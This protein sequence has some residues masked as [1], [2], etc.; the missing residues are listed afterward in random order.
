MKKAVLKIEDMTCEHCKNAVTKAISGVEGVS[1]VNVDLKKNQAE[2]EYDPETLDFDSIREAVEEAG[3]SV[4]GMGRSHSGDKAAPVKV[5]VSGEASDSKKC[6]IRVGGMTCASC[7]TNI[8]KALRRV[9]GVTSANVNFAAESATVEYDPNAVDKKTLEN[10]IADVGYKV[11]TDSI[12]FKITGMTCANCAMNIEKTLKKLEGISSVTVNFATESAIVYYDPSQITPA[13][14]KKAVEDI[15]YGAEEKIEG[16]AALDREMKQRQEEITRQRNNL[17]FAATLGILIMLGSYRMYWRL[18]EFVPEILSNNYMLLLLTTP[19]VLGPARQFFVGTY[20]GLKHGFTDMNLLMATGIGAA[21]LIGLINT[22]WPEVGLGGKHLIFFETAAMLTAFIVLGRYLEALTRGKTSEAIRKL[23]GLQPKNATIMRGGKEVEVSVNE[24]Q[25]GDIVVVKP[26]ERIPVDG[27]VKEGYSSVDESMLTGESIPVEKKV[28]DE[29]IGATIN[30]TGLLRFEATKV[31]KDTALAQIIKLVEEAQGSK[32]PIQKLAD[33]VAG[34]FIVGVHILALLVFFFWFFVGYDLFFTQTAKFVLSPATLGGVGP[35]AFALLLSISVLVIS[36]PCAVGLATPSAV[37]A[38]TGKAAEYG[39]LIKGGEALELAH[40]IKVIVFDKTGTL[41]KGQPSLT[42][43]IAAKGFE[44]DEVLGYAASAEKGSEHPLG[45]AIVNGA[46]S[47]GIRIEKSDAFQAIPGHGIVAKLADK[48]ILL[49]NRKLMMDNGLEKT[50][51]EETL[52]RLEDAGKTAMLVAIDK[53]IIGIVAVADTLK[54]YSKEAVEKLT[55]MGIEVV[56]MTGDNKRTAASIAKQVGIKRVLAEVLPQDKAN[57]I[58]KLQA[59]GKIVAMVG[60]G[61]NDA[62]ALAQA[63]VGIA[64]GT[65]TDIAKETGKIILIKEDLRDVVTAI[66]VSKKTIRKIKENLVWAFGYNTTGIPLGAGVLY[67]SLG[68]LISPELAALFM[69]MS[70][71]SVT[72]NTVRLRRY[73]PSI[74][75]RGESKPPPVRVTVSPGT[76]T[77][78]IGSD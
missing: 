37:M 34:H 19:V 44:V 2:F 10:T 43:V 23:M 72:L 36:C 26:G 15:G 13:Q 20:K 18:H 60:D 4:M 32:P 11:L 47:R 35:F 75:S 30:K 12:T 62:P 73:V 27:I 61:I 33:K 28:G 6:T 25:P 51:F 48:S 24:V 76:P 45:E 21:Y 42:D 9:E 17:I 22:I 78:A 54:E 57:E 1:K 66:E 5:H 50:Q 65:G 16:E 39:V 40:K 8:E 59:A 55:Q 3:Y 38:G 70:S 71:V 68:L 29:V 64:I 49:G 56:M 46:E 41:T 31:G 52:T 69:A 53:Q 63:D 14:M 77:G 74:R 58:R 67:P 7:A